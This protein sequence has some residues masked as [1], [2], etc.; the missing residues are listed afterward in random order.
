MTCACACACACT[1]TSFKAPWLPARSASYRP[2]SYRPA[3]ASPFSAIWCPPD[4]T[5]RLLPQVGRRSRSCAAQLLPCRA[6]GGQLRECPREGG[7]GE[8]LHARGPP[9]QRCR[10]LDMYMLDGVH[11]PE[12]C[13]YEEVCHV[14][15][16]MGA[17]CRRACRKPE[18]LGPAVGLDGPGEQSYAA[19]VLEVPTRVPRAT[20]VKPSGRTPPD[21][22][23]AGAAARGSHT[24][25]RVA[26][27]TPRRAVP[28]CARRSPGPVWG[29]GVRGAGCG[30][31][32]AACGVRRAACGVRRAC[33][34]TNS[35][36]APPGVSW[37]EMRSDQRSRL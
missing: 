25:G 28:S 31:R 19:I 22:A 4:R 37:A 27:P 15:G 5:R 21:A 6:A 10:C 16:D 34:S 14:C 36:G 7:A 29:C 13:T 33:F 3:P 12:H 1:Y 11:A 9:H 35:R 18:G 24:P 30:V 8:M 23:T 26:I 20:R 17:C 2:P 32:G